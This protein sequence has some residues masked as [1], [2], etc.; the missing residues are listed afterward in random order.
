MDV[1]Q[2]VLAIAT[3]VN[4]IMLVYQLSRKI[5]PEVKKLELE[6]DAEL[7][8]AAHLNLESAEVSTKLLMN[9]ID[10]LK[11]AVEEERKA[12]QDDANYFRRRIRELD[13]EARDYRLWAARLA[14]Q[15]IEAGKQPLPFIPSLGDSD[16]LIDAMEKERSD[17][18]RGKEAREAQIRDDKQ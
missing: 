1:E 11:K 7:V 4:T 8:D 9:R 14:K 6:G 2:I 5:K 17:L 10:E 18:E 3:L 15:V 16:P 13:R 12:R